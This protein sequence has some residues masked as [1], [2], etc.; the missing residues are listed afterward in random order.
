MTNELTLRYDRN[1]LVIG[2]RKG[3]LQ[4]SLTTQPAMPLMVTRESPWGFSVFMLRVIMPG[5]AV[6]LLDEIRSNQR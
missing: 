3:L 4:G 2:L 5:N 1:R 6:E